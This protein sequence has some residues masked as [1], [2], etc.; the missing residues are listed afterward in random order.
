MGQTREV[1]VHFPMAVHPDPAIGPSSFDLRLDALIE[2]KRTLTRDLFLPPDA[3]DADI[4]E[5]FREVSLS[6]AADDPAAEMAPS[7]SEELPRLSGPET[8]SSAI[9]AGSESEEE[10]GGEPLPPEVVLEPTEVARSILSVATPSQQA[11]I[12]MWRISA[13]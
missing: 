5:L 8:I 9:T 3:S 1:H 7:T 4:N 2:R 10:T 11:S 13:Y 12:R 6:D